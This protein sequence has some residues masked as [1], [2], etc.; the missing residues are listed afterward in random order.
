MVHFAA[1][2]TGQVL[3]LDPPSVLGLL[4]VRTELEFKVAGLP[5]DGQKHRE[6]IK[7]VQSTTKRVPKQSVQI[8]CPRLWY[9]NNIKCSPTGAIPQ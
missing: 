8:M 6:R 1:N 4:V 5:A 9:H 3:L 2:R 7:L